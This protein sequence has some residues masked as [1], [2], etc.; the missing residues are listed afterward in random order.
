M[1]NFITTFIA[2]LF[3]SLSSHAF[4]PPV[5]KG[6]NYMLV[7]SDSKKA[8]PSP[9]V[10]KSGT[11][12]EQELTEEEKQ[13]EQ[14]RK[15]IFKPLQTKADKLDYFVKEDKLQE[16]P[17]IRELL[18]GDQETR[19]AAI[20]RL[21]DYPE[22]ASPMVLLLGAEY[23]AQQGNKEKAAIYLLVSQLRAQFDMQRW[24][25]VNDSGLK[26]RQTTHPAKD[27]FSLSKQ[28]SKQIT[29]WA[30]ADK[31]R[32][33]KILHDVKLWDKKTSYAYRPTYDLPSSTDIET[34][35]DLHEAASKSFI[36]KQVEIITLIHP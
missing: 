34:W 1:F 22:F 11:D 15:A 35:R 24:P 5:K 9:D 7:K 21:E 10:E 2:I 32:A 33:L 23:Y 30:V 20:E 19:D 31:S 6:M 25:V 14:I 8:P 18:S 13:K 3:F 4:E 17:Y 26:S 27:T 12:E 28:V 36:D 16:F 29:G